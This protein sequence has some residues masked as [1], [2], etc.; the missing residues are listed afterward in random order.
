EGLLI[1]LRGLGEAADLPDVLKRGG[2]HLVVG[3]RRL[4]VVEGS[5][6]STHS[7]FHI[8]VR[9]AACR[10]APHNTGCPNRDELSSRRR[11]KS[12]RPSR[13][14]L[15]WDSAKRGQPSVLTAGHLQGP[16][17]TFRQTDHLLSLVARIV[18]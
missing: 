18:A 11:D 3:R 17:M 12:R 6:V 2:A 14:C 7:P 10:D 15:G 9:G 1:C 4:E 13:R 8:A 16:A 5:D